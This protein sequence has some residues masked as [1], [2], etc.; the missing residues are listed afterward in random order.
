[1]PLDGSLALLFHNRVGKTQ[2]AEFNFWKG[3][4]PF[5]SLQ[6]TSLNR[7]SCA[8]E[9]SLLKWQNQGLSKPWQML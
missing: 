8:L 2:Q 4:G 5:G 7:K 3:E 1:M 9:S 6:D